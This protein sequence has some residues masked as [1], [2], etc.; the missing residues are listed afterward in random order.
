MTPHRWPNATGRLSG[1]GFFSTVRISTFMA[2]R[3][4]S[5]RIDYAYVA[6]LQD[7]LSICVSTLEDLDAVLVGI[8]V[9]AWG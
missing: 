9:F 2:P 3:D 1:Q 5:C 6:G 7:V 8:G 4:E